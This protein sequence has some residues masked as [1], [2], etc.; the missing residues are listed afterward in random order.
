VLPR[1]L[2]LFGGDRGGE[3]GCDGRRVVLTMGEE[4]RRL[5]RRSGAA[6]GGRFRLVHA[7]NPSPRV[8]KVTG[9]GL[10]RHGRRILE[11][12]AESAG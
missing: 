5:L 2:G 9:A 7:P 4:A 11:A 8:V 10:N 12:L 3:G 1:L 6:S